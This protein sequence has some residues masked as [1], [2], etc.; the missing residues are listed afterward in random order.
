MQNGGT[1]QTMTIYVDCLAVPTDATGVLGVNDSSD[2][3]AVDLKVPPV[4]GYVGQDWPETCRDWTVPV[5][6]ADYGCDLW[7]EVTSI[8]LNCI[9]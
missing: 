3:W 4:D 2:E 8:G 9:N 1:P 7:L 5:D 6:G